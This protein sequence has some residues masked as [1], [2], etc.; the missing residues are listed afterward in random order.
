MVR[1]LS[2][3]I[4]SWAVFFEAE[5]DVCSLCNVRAHA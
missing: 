4:V 1:H 3:F 5:V 2:A